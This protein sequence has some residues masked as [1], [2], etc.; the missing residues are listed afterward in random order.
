MLTVRTFEFNML[1]VNT[2]L[3]WDQTLQA[4]IIDPG[5][6]YPSESDQLLQAVTD[7]N[8]TVK[9]ILNT[10][11]HFDHIFGNPD[12]ERLF[13]VRAKA[14]MLDM[15]WLLDISRRVGVFG[16]RYDKTVPPI[17][18]E[19]NLKD[20]DTI[21]F[22]DTILEVLA[23]PGHSPGGLGFYSRK[24][25]V[26][27]S[28]DSLFQGSIGRTDFP[29]SDHNALIDAIRSSLLPLPEDTVV[30][31]GHGPATTIGFEKRYNPYIQA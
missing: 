22:G 2:Y 8:L 30:Y 1:P 29:D 14:S 10:H 21:S 19:N 27:F 20:G 5:C 7:N 31:T 28:G 25:S 26:L 4:V 16:I 12:A 11:L 23:L 3:V 13:G 9:H 6:Y 15:P 24:D 18:P 17:L